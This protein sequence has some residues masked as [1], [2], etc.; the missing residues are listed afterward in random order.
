MPITGVAIITAAMSKPFILITIIT[1]SSCGRRS[2][3]G[4]PSRKF[5]NGGGNNEGPLFFSKMNDVAPVDR[6]HFWP[7]IPYGA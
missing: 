3:A 6:R 1:F 4:S 5:M 7:R 2:T